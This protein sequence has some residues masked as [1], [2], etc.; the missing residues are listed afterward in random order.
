MERL[1]MGKYAVK[2]I[3]VITKLSALWRHSA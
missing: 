3:E 2:P 1:L